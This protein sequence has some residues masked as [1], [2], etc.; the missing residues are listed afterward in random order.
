MLV[1]TN[2]VVARRA[3]GGDVSGALAVLGHA[4]LNALGTLRIGLEAL[5]G[6]APGVS[7]DD[8]ALLVAD[9]REEATRLEQLA[10]AMV[11]GTPAP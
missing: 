3:T 9:I 10:R 6:G 7:V 4:C 11:R 2:R 1:E 5:D 8:Q